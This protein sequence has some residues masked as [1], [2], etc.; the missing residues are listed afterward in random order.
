MV[1]TQKPL[2]NFTLFSVFILGFFASLFISLASPA[3]TFAV[4]SCS[5][6]LVQG[7]GSASKPD[8]NACYTENPDGTATADPSAKPTT[9][10]NNDTSTCAIEMIGWILCPIMKGAGKMT[11]YAFEVLAG[12]FLEVQPELFDNGS[13]TKKSWEQAR[14]LANVLFVIAFVVLIYSQITGGLMS[15]YGIKRMLP[16]LIIAAVAVNVSYYI[17]QAMVDISNI[18]GYN[19]KDALAEMSKDLP[20][21]LG[22]GFGSTG[23]GK[24]GAL[25]AVSI[26]VVA[27]AWAI[28]SFGAAI[29]TVVLVTI[30]TVVVILLLRKA[31]IILLI[32]VSPLAFV[33][34]LLPNTEKYF[35]KWLN[36]FT[37]LLMVFPIVALLMGAGQLASG[38]VLNAG[39][40]RGQAP[41]SCPQ[42]QICTQDG[43]TV[44]GET[45]RFDTGKGQAP[46]SLGLVAAGI[47]IAPLLFVWSVLKGAIAA[48]GA[49]GG[50]I[51]KMTD[52]GAR[53]GVG[54][55]VDKYKN[56]DWVKNRERKEHHMDAQVRAGTF[57]ATGMNKFRVVK[58]AKSRA[59]Q[60]TR[61]KQIG[62]LGSYKDI[63]AQALNQK[64][65]KEAMDLF[66]GDAD[67]AR[68]FA[69]TGGKTDKDTV[70][71]ALADLGID[72][73]DWNEGRQR[74]LKAL[75]KG[76]YGHSA[77]SYMAAANFL[78]ESGKGTTQDLI[79]AAHNAGH[80]GATDSEVFS[81]YERARSTTRKTG[82]VDMLADLEAGK[83]KGYQGFQANAGAGNIQ[84]MMG[85]VGVGGI[86]YEMM[87]G[88]G[89]SFDES[90]GQVTGQKMANNL[91]AFENR[92]NDDENIAG[93]VAGMMANG[94]LAGMQ[95][96]NVLMQ[97][98][99]T[100]RAEVFEDLVIRKANEHIYKAGGQQ[101]NSLQAAKNY[102]EN[103][104]QRPAA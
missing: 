11:D 40:D 101:V 103:R 84:S 7:D 52:K 2:R 48:V 9:T 85:D 87:K 23:E 37:Q 30:V 63:T 57:K 15:N 65:A 43:F 75:S 26:G 24:L 41:A 72:K 94:R 12:F 39:I 102:F 60:F 3:T 13:P 28:Y 76:G 71:K 90:T 6:A 17:C 1:G 104:G 70:D 25:I 22:G 80:S 31:F 29:V 42:G 82:R 51:S 73:K 44:G 14:N 58:R 59:N 98:D 16:R 32:V 74:K 91:D 64:E 79:N 20:Q 8:T 88:G 69:A 66:D 93:G 86:N 49:I 4:G 21:V 54:Y 55:G 77:A 81:M 34:Y 56:S 97:A 92:L 61:D 36:M 38:I 89:V 45:V 68:M 33:A 46:P 99:G 67:T 62:T 18:L 19:I 100:K 5:G 47:A 96:G 78:G 95:T 10:G 53:A 50:T 35:T 27:I 83:K